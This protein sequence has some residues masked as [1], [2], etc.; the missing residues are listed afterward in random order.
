MRRQLAPASAIAPLATAQGGVV[1]RAQLLDLGLSSQSIDRR[2]QAQQLL[3]LYRGVYAVGHR[4]L[5]TEARRWAAVFACGGE[6]VLSHGTAAAAWGLRPDAGPI[7][8][9]VGRGGRARRPGIVV[10]R[11]GTLTPGQV[12]TRGGIPVTTPGRAVLDLAA[13]GLRDRPLEKLLDRRR[14][15]CWTSATYASC[16]SRTRAGRAR[17]RSGRCCPATRPARS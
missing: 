17:R 15:C 6:A 12:T 8:V 11:S 3:L 9:T 5:N 10:H 7:H 2:V 13:A 16:C 1:S 4:T 14:R